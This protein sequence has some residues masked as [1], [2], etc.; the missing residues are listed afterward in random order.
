MIQFGTP[1]ILLLL[2]T[3]CTN[4]DTVVEDKSLFSE[5]IIANPIEP[6]TYAHIEPP[7]G[8]QEQWIPAH[9][10]ITDPASPTELLFHPWAHEATNAS[11]A[12]KFDKVLCRINYGDSVVS[13]PYILKRDSIEIFEYHD[14]LTSK[15]IIR[16]LTE[17]S[18][19]VSWETGDE[20]NYVRYREEAK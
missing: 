5:A 4:A 3:A 20:N 14:G 9:S 10:T 8:Q 13:V 2:V 6:T 7:F 18:L 1:I 19:I 15:G 16:K 11:Y 17:D 12:M